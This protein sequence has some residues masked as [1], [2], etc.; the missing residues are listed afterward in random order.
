MA[1]LIAPLPRRRARRIL[2]RFEGL[3]AGAVFDAWEDWQVMGQL[4]P[5]QRGMLKASSRAFDLSDFIGEHVQR[6]FAGVSAATVTMKYQRPLVG[7]ADGLVQVRFKKLSPKLAVSFSATTRQVRLA[8]HQDEPAL[9][10]LPSPTVITV[11]YVL[12]DTETNLQKIVAVCH[13]GKR[14]EYVVPL[15]MP[16]Q[17]N[18]AP[19]LLAAAPSRRT[20]VRSARLGTEERGS[21]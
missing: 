14:V 19:T 3:L 5:I 7:L 15:A 20:L 10:G 8:L 11:G 13:V 4:A 16:V 21:A 6:R 12:D 1:T 2:G 18:A 17:A 9:P